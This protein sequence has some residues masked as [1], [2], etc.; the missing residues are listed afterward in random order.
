MASIAFFSSLFPLAVAVVVAVLLV[1]VVVVLWTADP[2][3][4]HVC[5]FNMCFIASFFRKPVLAIATLDVRHSLQ[6]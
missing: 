4:N 5:S 1:V 2:K 6:S 3:H